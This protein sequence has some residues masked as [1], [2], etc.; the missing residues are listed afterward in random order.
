MGAAPARAFDLKVYVDT[1]ADLRLIRR[2]RR[3][4]AER[5]RTTESI[6][7]QY[8]HT[9]RPSHDQF[10]E[11]SKRHADVIFPQGGMNEPAIEM[12]AGPRQGRIR[13]RSLTGRP[14]RLPLPTCLNGCLRTC[15]A[16]DAALEDDG[17]RLVLVDVTRLPRVDEAALRRAI[18]E[19]R[20]HIAV[21]VAIRRTHRRLVDGL[22]HRRRSALTTD[23]WVVTVLAW[24][25]MGFVILGNGAVVHETLH[26]HLFRSAWVNRAVGNVAGAWV[27]LPWSTYRAY[28]LGHHQSSCTP[29]DPEGPPYRFTNRWSPRSSLSAAR[30][31]RARSC[32]GRCAPS[33]GRRRRSS[34]RLV[35]ARDVAFDGLLSIAFYIGMIAL[36]VHDVHLLATVWL[37]P[38]LFAVVVLEPLVLIPE[39]YGTSM[40]DA[41]RHCSPPARCAPTDCSPGSTGATTSTLPTTWHRAWSHSTSGR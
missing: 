9:V 7:E 19:R 33:P 31:S 13:A 8:L 26:G 29:D 28:H 38:W 27:G 37:V 11:P 17:G 2:L 6:I 14:R 18:A 35:N 40:D 15:A 12:P 30:C 24:V 10:I 23:H 34:G 39:H 5:G 41:A 22:R 3:D 25:C 21:P 32:G 20:G 4:V 1:D 36:A 16:H